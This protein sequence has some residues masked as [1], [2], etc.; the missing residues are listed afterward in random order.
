MLI[1][2]SPLAS[3]SWLSSVIAAVELLTVK[4]PPTESA[5]VSLRNLKLYSPG[6]RPAVLSNAAMTVIVLAA[7][8]SLN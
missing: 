8:F 5:P 7:I 6:I 4:Y 1:R 2:C 3:P